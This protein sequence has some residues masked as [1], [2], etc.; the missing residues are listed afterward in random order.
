MIE[1]CHHCGSVLINGDRVVMMVGYV[2]FEFCLPFAGKNCAAEYAK[3]V[4]QV[5]HFAPVSH[6]RH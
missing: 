6:L 3:K 1:T 5:A 2:Q 4:Q